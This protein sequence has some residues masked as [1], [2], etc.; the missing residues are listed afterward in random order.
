MKNI[1]GLLFPM[2]LLLNL[3]TGCGENSRTQ[4]TEP[5]TITIWH[6]YWEHLKDETDELIDVFNSTVGA[7]EGIIVETGFVA[8]API[9]YENL[10]MAA[11]GGIG[12]PD[13]PDIA[14]FIRKNSRKGDLVLIMGAGNVGEVIPLIIDD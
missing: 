2:A 7:E 5:V 11:D 10:L 13:F 1:V 4:Q 6:T 14:D 8:D 3:L 9:L 12:A